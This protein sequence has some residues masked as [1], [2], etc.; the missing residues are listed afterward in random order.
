MIEPTVDFPEAFFLPSPYRKRDYEAKVKAGRDILAK[1]SVVVIGLARN[2]ASVLPKTIYRIERL[3]ELCKRSHVVVFENDSRDTTLDI[4]KKWSQNTG[5]VTVL[6]D[7]FGHPVNQSVRSLTRATR[8]AHYRGICQ[9]H[10]RKNHADSSYVVV[11]DLD[12]AGGFSLDGVCNSVGHKHADFC[13]A[14][15]ILYHTVLG[16]QDYPV[17][18][19]VWAY[20]PRGDW[21]PVNN[22]VVNPLQ[23]Y[24]GDALVPVNSAFGGLGVYKT[25]AYLAG[26]YDGTDCEHVPFHR[27]MMNAGHKNLFLNPS[28]VVLY[29]D[30]RI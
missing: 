17:Q 13:A 14:N 7:N 20:R 25:P 12:I 26:T 27:S 23:F 3:R 28:Q 16:I 8:M 4:L 2:I 24:R 22:S 10:V 15:G 29:N 21:Q 6:N 11:I 30:V 9:H 19:D 18:Y 1:S 5:C